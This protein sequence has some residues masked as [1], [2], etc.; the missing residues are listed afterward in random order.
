MLEIRDLSF[1][2]GRGPGV[3]RGAEL[4]LRDGEI[5]VV[6]G[7]NGAGKTT[8]FKCILGSVRPE[9]GSIRFDGEEL[10]R[11]SRRE[12][13]RRIAYVPQDV[14]F[15][16]LRVYDTVLLGRV[17]YFGARPGR[18]DHEAAER[19]LRDMGLEALADRSAEALSGGEKQKLAV[20]RALCQEPRLLVFDE[21]T[22]NLDLQNEQLI[23]RQARS[24]AR[25]RGVSV[26]TA[27]HDLNEALALGDRF[28]FLKDGKVFREG[29][30]ETVTAETIEEVYGARV[31]VLQAEG[32]TILLNDGGD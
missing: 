1:R 15:G 9:G 14:R 25:E 16:D 2:Y 32:K 18:E 28:F 11:M 13:A 27:L 20:A 26:L 17:A 19:V 3:L 8:L 10:S 4:T 22:G 30:R 21:P 29:G 6:L 23:L 7:K 12:R 24:A 31:R 5:G